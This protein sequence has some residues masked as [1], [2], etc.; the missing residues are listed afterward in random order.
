MERKLFETRDG[1]HSIAIPELEVM[2]HSIHGAIQESQHVFI[3]AG[4]EKAIQE[5]PGRRLRIFEMGFGTGLN[6]LLTVLFTATHKINVDYITIEKFPLDISMVATLNYCSKL[7]VEELQPV[8]MALHSSDEKEIIA[9]TPYFTFQKSYTGIE[10]LPGYITG[11]DVIYFDAFAPKAQPEL[12]ATE[13]FQLLWQ[14]ANP[15]AILTTYCSKSWVRRNIE[16]AGWKIE[17]IP[18]PWGKREMVR[19]K[20]ETKRE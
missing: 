19:A 8:F 2:Y 5:N 18:G 20:K 1:S 12:W 3:N 7:G 4:L 10:Q 17:K 11:L 9:A 6:A 13:I 14:R 16:A 15:G